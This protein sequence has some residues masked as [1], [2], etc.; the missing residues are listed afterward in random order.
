M[1]NLLE[2][3]NIKKYFP[4]YDGGVIFKKHRMLKAVDS[5]T[6]SVKKGECFG[7]AG[8]SGSGKTTVAKLLLLLEKITEGNIFFEGKNLR[9]LTKQERRWYRRSVQTIF[10]DAASSLN[11]RMR[12]QD[13]VSEPM[14]V[15]LKGMR[16][17][18]TIRE[19]A[20]EILRLVGLGSANLRKYP[21]E[22]SGGQKQ[23][24]AIARAIILEPSLIILDEPVSALDVS[25]RAQILNLLTEIQEKQDI[26]YLLIAH[27]LAML[28][29][30]TDHIAVMYLGKVVEMG[31]TEKLFNNPMHPYTKALFAAVPRPEPGRIKVVPAISGEIGNPINPPL[32]CRFHPRCSQAVPECKTTEPMIQNIGNFHQAA[33]HCITA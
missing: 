26:T 18:N 13:I 16:L 22:L 2:A 19:R 27:D 31:E 12:I 6:F 11:P 29:N 30:V 5:V 3:K 24:V 20:E 4:I 14:E 17:K 33:C 8:E 10:Q 1:E 25:I 15:Q 28:Q 32:G 23:R 9:Q 7:I 21:H